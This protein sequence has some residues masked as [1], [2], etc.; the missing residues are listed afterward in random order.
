[1]SKKELA[2]KKQKLIERIEKL[3]AQKAHKKFVISCLKD[4]DYRQMAW[5]FWDAFM[6][7]DG[8]RRHS[9]SEIWNALP[10][11]MRKFIE[12]A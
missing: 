8:K 9:V 10:S 11:N 5:F 3:D 7:W 4:S 12:H 2:E 6:M 1:M